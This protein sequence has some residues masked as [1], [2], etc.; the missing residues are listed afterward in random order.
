MHEPHD[1]RLPVTV[2]AGMSSALRERLVLDA[3]RVRAGACAVVYDLEPALGGI[4]LIRR[5]LD[6]HGELDREPVPLIGCCLACTVRADVGSALDLVAGADR[7]SQA[8]VSVPTSVT[9]GP[10]AS[11][12][13]GHGAA[14][15]DTTAVVV[16]AVLLASQLAGAEPLAGRGMQAAPT[17]YRST[18]DL[19]VA[20][21]EDA[22]VLVLTGLHRLGRDAAAHAQALLA[23]LAPLAVQVPVGADGSGGHAAVRTGRSVEPCSRSE[24]E[25]LAVLAAGLCAPSCGVTTTVWT[26]DRPLH[27][28][29]LRD[30]LED[31]VRGV[32]RSRGH[33][34]LAGRPGQ[35]IRWESAG[36]GL[37]FG[38]P[39]LFGG[40]PGCQLLLTGTGLDTGRLTALLDA[41][42]V[43][44]G[45]DPGADPFAHALGPAQ[46]AEHP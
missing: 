27:P 41:C 37:S 4:V 2:I 10:V 18:A 12:L 6:R 14:R 19:L 17:D 9:P 43:E 35:R 25:R 23:H 26:S 5:L 8:L 15:P 34:C 32:V 31:V 45:A 1:D 16:D 21:L 28:A 24:R 42:L 22:D 30:V 39:V 7:W 20:Q 40:P 33:I 44:P 11:S 36:D 13:T 3:V 46:V 29:R 38:D